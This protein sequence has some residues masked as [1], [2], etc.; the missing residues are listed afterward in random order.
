[1]RNDVIDTMMTGDEDLDIGKSFRRAH[2]VI[3]HSL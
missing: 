3:N 1:M 2:L